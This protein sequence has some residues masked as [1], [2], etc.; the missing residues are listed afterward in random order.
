M[1][2]N[3]CIYDDIASGSNL[4]VHPIVP[5]AEVEPIDPMVLRISETNEVDCDCD[6]DLNPNTDKVLI[7]CTIKDCGIKVQPENML[8]D[9]DLTNILAH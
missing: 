3:M 8:R 1:V 2:V 7:D 6:G 9:Q 5:I 4:S